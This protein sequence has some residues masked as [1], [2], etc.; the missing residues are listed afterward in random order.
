M[1][2]AVR[3]GAQVDIA[4]RRADVL[5]HAIHWEQEHAVHVHVILAIFGA[6]MEI[7]RRGVLVELSQ[8][9]LILLLQAGEVAAWW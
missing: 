3:V 7:I 2:V 4:W 6:R 1:K 8:A 9:L 5:Q